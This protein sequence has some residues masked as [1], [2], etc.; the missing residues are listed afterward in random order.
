MNQTMNILD[1]F[2]PSKKNDSTLTKP[3]TTFF[4]KASSL[5][6]QTG[7]FASVFGTGY[8]VGKRN[9]ALTNALQKKYALGYYNALVDINKTIG[10]S[11]SNFLNNEEDLDM[12]EIQKLIAFQK[13]LLEQK[14]IELKN[15]P[16]A[17][18]PLHAYKLPP[19]HL[20]HG[21]IPLN[22]LKDMASA[23]GASSQLI[24]RVK[25]LLPPPPLQVPASGEKGL[26]SD[27]DQLDSG[28]SDSDQLGSEKTGSH[29]LD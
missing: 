19:V 28:E 12:G 14:Y 18:H 20:M 3:S 1:Y 15:P 24:G 17:Y 11:A 26:E 9:S 8:L 27:S 2:R 5:L 4:K 6:T 21:D 25:P 29:D 22:V 13:K 23:R 16:L 10:N 7:L